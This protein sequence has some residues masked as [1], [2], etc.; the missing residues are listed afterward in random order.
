MVRMAGRKRDKPKAQDLHGFKYF[1]VISG[2]LETLHEACSQRD[3]AHNRILHM[4]QYVTLLL[5]YSV[6][7]SARC[8]RPAI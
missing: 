6:V 3:R 4:D 8:R 5:M 1:K 7:R 2:L